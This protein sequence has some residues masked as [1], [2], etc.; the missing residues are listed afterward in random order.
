MSARSRWL[1]LATIALAVSFNVPY[2]VLASIFDYP[3]ILREPAGEVLSRFAAGGTGLL[4]TWYAFALTALALVPLAAGLAITPVRLADRPAL[5]IG[6]ALAGALAGLTQAIGLVRWVF[7][8]PDLSRAATGA[9]PAAAEAAIGT[10][11]LINAYGGIAVGEH[12]GQL[13]TALFA[14]LLALLQQG[15]GHHATAAFGLA[16]AALLTFGTGEG[17]MLA[18]GQDGS[19]F[20]VGTITGFLALTVW[21]IATGTLL[22]RRA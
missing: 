7:V 9:D 1:G 2:A 14:G 18:A 13:L 5:A 15:E 4:L 16:T 17:L 19:L 10:F 3:A 8:M 21:L 22:L 6:A 20:A 11:T 12:L